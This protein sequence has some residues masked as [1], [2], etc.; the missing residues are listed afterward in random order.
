MSDSSSISFLVDHLPL[1]ILYIRTM[2]L[3]INIP[4]GVTPPFS[5]NSKTLFTLQL[6]PVCR[7]IFW[8]AAVG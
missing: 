7:G 3:M 5:T 8:L 6:S 1:F 4:N 2:E